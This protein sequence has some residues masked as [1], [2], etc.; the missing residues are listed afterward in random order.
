MQWHAGN[1]L[2]QTVYTFLYVHSLSDM[3]PEFV[4]RIWSFNKE[5]SSRPLE[6]VTIVLRSAVFGLLKSCALA[7]IELA[8]GRVYD[9][10]TSYTYL[11]QLTITVAR[12]LA[13]RKIRDFS[14]RRDTHR[15]SHLQTR[16]SYILASQ[17][18]K[19]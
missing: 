3:D 13:F 5:D 15:Y 7:W 18:T 4:S 12:R 10:S 14:L 17:H 19:M 16:R 9:V 6:L 1:T 11:S 2:S 8:K